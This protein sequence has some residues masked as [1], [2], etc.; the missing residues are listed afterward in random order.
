MSKRSFAEFTN[1]SPDLR[2]RAASEHVDSLLKAAKALKKDLERLT[3]HDNA[4][5]DEAITSTLKQHN[6][7]ILSL[8]HSLSQDGDE[9]REQIWF[10]FLSSNN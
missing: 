4:L 7:Q 5:S 6:T 3:R 9:V 8:A 2:F 1:E 10:F